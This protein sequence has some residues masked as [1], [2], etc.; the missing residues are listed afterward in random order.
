M[1]PQK[2][3]C[4]QLNQEWW[5]NAREAERWKPKYE[6]M[7]EI[8]NVLTGCED[9]NVEIEYG[10]KNHQKGR[11]LMKILTRWLINENH[12]W[13]RIAILRVMPKLIQAFPKKTI[14]KYQNELSETIMTKQW[15]EKKKALW[16]LATPTLMALWLKTGF[17][18]ND[19]EHREKLIA[20]LKHR[21]KECRMSA[22]DFIAKCTM[23]PKRK[24]Q[25]V[26]LCEDRDIG[27]IL[28]G[29][30]QSDKDKTVR[31]AACRL[32]YGLEQCG[33]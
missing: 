5:D 22:A 8:F 6:C 14:M 28:T 20:A 33:A 19:Y 31:L 16:V 25:V 2:D 26:A 4:G 24:K 13:T 7:K 17:E 9:T 10:I 3:L 11:A 12:V 23:Y 15:T 1:Q 32:F 21:G 30:A 18:L 27:K 29:L